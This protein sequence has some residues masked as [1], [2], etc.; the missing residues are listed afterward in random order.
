MKI[1]SNRKIKTLFY[2][3]LMCILIFTL[4]SASFMSLKLENAA[5]YILICS[6]CMGIGIL[7]ACYRYFKEQN[8]I[9][10]NAVT[11][12]TE[13][14]SG[15]RTA[16]IE[17]DDEGELYR[18]FHEV[19]SLVSILNAHA[20]NEGKAKQFLKNTISDISHQ[21]KTPL[22]ALNIYNGLL[23][24]EAEELPTIKE[25][26]TL[27]EHEL[28]RIETLVQNLLK[29]TK[30]DAGSIV[31]EKAP[32]NVADM[33]NDIE[34]H[35][36]YRAKQEQKEIVLSGAENISLLCDCDWVMEAIDNIVKNALDHT[37]KGDSIHVE[38]KQF[39]T[40]VQIIV[41]DNGSGIH[42]E[43]LHHIF[44]RFYRSRFSKD[45]PGIGLGL[46]LTKAIIEAHNGTVEVDSELGVGTTFV[47]N[48]LIPT[49]L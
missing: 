28:D 37:Q 7:I 32:E 41:K 3:I 20:E 33:M 48:F 15:N 46:P 47:I 16:R 35:F 5:F 14:I 18:L 22:A 2:M 31:I 1:L 44:K 23:Q 6:L 45:I 49:K 13:Y 34:L 19:N 42:P 9:M 10:E 26:A 21:L 24:G 36:A 39:M 27:S 25:F 8:K 4:L 11:Q 43:D 40:V 29:I 30:L 17:C 38:W 12:I